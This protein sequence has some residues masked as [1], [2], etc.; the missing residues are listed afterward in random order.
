MEG[1]FYTAMPDKDVRGSIFLVNRQHTISGDYTPEVR[2][3]KVSGASQS[4]NGAA[5]TALEEMF[6]AAK[7]E[8]N[9]S[10]AAVSGYRGFRKQDILYSRKKQS[11]G[12]AKADMLVAMPGTSEHQLGMAMDISQNGS[13]RLNANFGK[14][15]G[16]L[17]ISENAHRFGYIVRY[18][19][20]YEDIT[21]YSYEPWHVRYVGIEH[22]KAIY[23]SKGPMEFH[24][25]DH[26][27]ILYEYLIRF[28]YG[29]V[30]P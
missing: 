24:I 3:A 14:T 17:W 28:A 7:E 1:S 25:S 23:E 30:V 27:L 21:G 12:S 18:Q 5:A 11:I 19:L 2:K 4:M 8:S 22:A 13:S 15:K 16:G 6:K 20:G 10:L 29:E 26:R 9:I